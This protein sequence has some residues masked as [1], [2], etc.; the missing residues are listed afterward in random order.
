MLKRTKNTFRMRELEVL[1]LC[2][3]GITPSSEPRFLAESGFFIDLP[4]MPLWC[5]YIRDLSS[6]NCHPANQASHSQD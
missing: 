4:I 3:D 2:N 5:C 6:S 1:C